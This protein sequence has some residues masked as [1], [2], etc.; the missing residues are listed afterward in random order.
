MERLVI[1]DA[2]DTEKVLVYG[3]GVRFGLYLKNIIAK[4]GS[5]KILIVGLVDDDIH[6]SGRVISGYK[7]LS[8]SGNMSE[9]ARTCG[10]TRVLITYD[11]SEDKICQ[12]VEEFEGSD[13]K[14]S[15]WRCTEEI[16]N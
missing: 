13:I 2:E 5:N 7:V 9:L 3:G 10:A 8:R 12:M 6:L 15:I 4:A 14:L 11:M 16:L 1:R